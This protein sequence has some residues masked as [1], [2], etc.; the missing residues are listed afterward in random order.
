[1]CSAIRHQASILNRLEENGETAAALKDR[2]KGIEERYRNVL[3]RMKEVQQK[4]Q[5]ERVD[6]QGLRQAVRQIG[7]W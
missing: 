5:A 7:K 2:V 6:E 1:M 4:E 3:R